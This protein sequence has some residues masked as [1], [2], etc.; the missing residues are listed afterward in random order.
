VVKFSYGSG[1]FKH[2]VSQC[3]FSVVNVSDDTEVANLLHKL[4]AERLK[5]K[6]ESSKLKAQS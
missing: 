6:A 5:T 1:N 4:K 3:R 2:S